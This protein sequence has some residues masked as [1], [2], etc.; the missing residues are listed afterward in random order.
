MSGIIYGVDCASFQGSPDWA[1]VSAVCRFGAE[2]VTEGTTYINPR[3]AAAKTGMQAVAAHGFVPLAYLFLDAGESGTAQAQ[4]FSRA[5][6]DLTGFGIVVDGERAP[7]GPTTRTQAEDAVAEL[8]RL[9]PGHP[10]GGYLPHWFTGTEDLTFA[11]WLWASQYVLGSGDPGVLYRQV[12]ASWWAAYGGRTPLLLQFT[13]AAAVAGITGAVDASAFHGDEAQLAAHVLPRSAAPKPTAP[14]TPGAQDMHLPLIPGDPAV[15]LPA[16]AYASA[17]GEPAAYEHCSLVITGATGYVVSVVLHEPG[18]KTESFTIPVRT[19]EAHPV[20]PAHGWGPV[21]VVE[22]K[23]L[24][25]RR[26]V[27]ASAVFRTW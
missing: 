24:D 21:Q 10:I 11:D 5:A 3:W 1:R 14:A 23:R 9:Y 27:G 19:G 16:W 17:Y 8:R 4:Y 22:I 18:G 20:V 15:T 26:A 12:P 2:K 6:G 7:N 13:S 25:T